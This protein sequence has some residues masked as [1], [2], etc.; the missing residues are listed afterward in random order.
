MTVSKINETCIHYVVGITS[1]GSS[2]CGY[3][4]PGVY[5]NILSFLNWIED[6][7]WY[8]NGSLSSGRSKL[9]TKVKPNNEGL[10]LNPSA[11]EPPEKVS[12]NEVLNGNVQSINKIVSESLDSVKSSTS[13]P[14][15]STTTSTTTTATNK[16]SPP[17]SKLK[18]MV[19]V[20]PETSHTATSTTILD[21]VLTN[22]PSFTQMNAGYSVA[23][24]SDTLSNLLNQISTG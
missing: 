23:N 20:L 21:D 2:L 7:V 10:V 3:Q 15:T 5:T 16:V 4:Q 17:T 6:V 24:F 18:T 14:M 9:Y 22:W 19:S 13:I 8:N 11:V 12:S 1:F